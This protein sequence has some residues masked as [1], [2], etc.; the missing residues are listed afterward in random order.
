MIKKLFIRV[1]IG[2]LP[3]WI[4]QWRANV[5]TLEQ[6]G[7]D[8]LI[9]TDAELVHRRMKEKLGIDLLI[10]PGSKKS[11]D[12]DPCYGIIFEEEIR[13]YDFWGH[14][15]LDVV[16]GRLDRFVSDEFLSDCDIF[17]NDPNAICGPFSLY[18]N[19]PKV[20]NLFKEV[21]DWQRLLA[22][23]EAV[24][25][26]ELAFSNKVVA[27]ALAGEIRFKSEFWQSHDHMLHQIPPSVTLLKDG[28]LMDVPKNEEIMMYHFNQTRQWPIK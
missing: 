3:S 24:A 22:H 18:R 17:G 20:N 25:F 23:P 5:K 4:D 8:F 16:L 27:S 12:I 1:W 26:D 19:T 14:T 10:K 9:I 21:V 15:N 7:F 6:Y 28:T 2:P 11:G 13:G